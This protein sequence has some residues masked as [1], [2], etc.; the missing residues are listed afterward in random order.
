MY[1]GNQGRMWPGLGNPHKDTFKMMLELGK[2]DH[3]ELHATFP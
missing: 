2:K 1:E 3:F